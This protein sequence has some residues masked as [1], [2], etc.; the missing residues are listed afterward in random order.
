VTLWNE[1]V[2]CGDLLVRHP[3]KMNVNSRYIPSTSSTYTM[4][5]R[6]SDRKYDDGAIEMRS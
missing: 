2:S 1:I 3:L 5:V 4:S 6:K